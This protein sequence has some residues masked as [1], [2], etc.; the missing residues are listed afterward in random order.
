M[1]IL[2]RKY[3]GEKYIGMFQL[4]TPTLMLLEPQMVKQI[5]VKD[6]QHFTDRGFVYDDRR[7]PLTANLVNLEGA[8]W[9]VL[10]QKL[11]PTF[12]SGKIKNMM[13]LL[14]DCSERLLL[15]LKVILKFPIGIVRVQLF[16]RF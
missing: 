2:F 6:F 4:S 8:K 14:H 3:K 1:I 5:L 10:R 15:Y 7:E 11:T 13:S 12:S 9:R 16:I